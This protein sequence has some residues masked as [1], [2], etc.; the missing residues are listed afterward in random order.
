MNYLEPLGLVVFNHW[1]FNLLGLKQGVV[2]ICLGIFTG[3]M[4]AIHFGWAK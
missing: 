3:H 4:L 1:F 2:P